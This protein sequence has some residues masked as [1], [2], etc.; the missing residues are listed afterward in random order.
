MKLRVRRR[1]K[2]LIVER[3]DGD[4]DGGYYMIPPEHTLSEGMLLVAPGDYIAKPDDTDWY[5]LAASV[6]LRDFDIL[7]Q[8]ED[9]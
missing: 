7:G 6:L 4:A 1:P 5:P 3:Y 8:V 2:E 9:G